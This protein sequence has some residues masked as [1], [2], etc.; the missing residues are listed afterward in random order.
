MDQNVLFEK[1]KEDGSTATHKYTEEEI[2]EKLEAY[3]AT[4][5]TNPDLVF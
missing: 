4:K 3:K 5:E 1:A 2:Q